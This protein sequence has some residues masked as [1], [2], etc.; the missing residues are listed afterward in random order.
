MEGKMIK[1]KKLSSGYYYIQG[2][3]PCNWIQPSHWPCSEEEIRQSAFPQASETF[4]RECMSLAV[5]ETRD[6]L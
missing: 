6:H 5:E 1:V 3:G 2:S 4:I